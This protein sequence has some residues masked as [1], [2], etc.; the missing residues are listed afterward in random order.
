MP[1][2]SFIA[3]NQ[4]HDMHDTGNSSALCAFE[5]DPTLIQMGDAF[6]QELVTEIKKSDAWR[7]GKNV[8]VVLWDEND[9]SSLPNK[10]VAIIETD[11]GA[12]GIR[13]GK[14][15]NHFSLLKTLE[16]GF[17]L[18]C[19]NHACDDTVQGMSDLLGF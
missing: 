11:Y 13:S 10:F 16:T 12:M 8:I 19:V 18:E 6:L 7:D 5:P 17:G 9:F 4:C 1:N 3:P 15:Y 14:L 2:F